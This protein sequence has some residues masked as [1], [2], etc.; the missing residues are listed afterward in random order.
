M[1]V[2]QIMRKKIAIVTASANKTSIKMMESR[3]NN[4][5]YDQAFGIMNWI[6]ESLHASAIMWEKR[7]MSVQVED[8][9]YDTA[10][11][12]ALNQ[13]NVINTIKNT[14]TDFNVTYDEAWQMPYSVIQSKS[15]A[16]ATAAH[17]QMKME[18]LKETR[19]K[20]N[21]KKHS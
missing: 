15:Y 9:D 6:K 14:C 20:A 13:F 2:S 4:L 12:H 17:I 5:P 8:K 21:Q 3:V 11:G 1:S 7:F 19:M 18:K 10:G 16:K